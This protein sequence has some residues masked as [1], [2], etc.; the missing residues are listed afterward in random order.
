MSGENKTQT[1]SAIVTISAYSSKYFDIYEVKEAKIR[2]KK[3]IARGIDVSGTE[4]FTLKLYYGDM[5]VFPKEGAVNITS[6]KREYP[7]D[8]I[9]Y[10]KDTIRGWA[11]NNASADRTIVI[12]VVYEVLED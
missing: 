7:L 10:N 12:D 11:Y 6:A 1:V 3:L 5:Q 4:F 9:Y 8:V 2:V